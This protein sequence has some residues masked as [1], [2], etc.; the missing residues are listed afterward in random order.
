MD[1]LPSLIRRCGANIDKRIHN[2]HT[3]IPDEKLRN[4]LM[5]GMQACVPEADI[6]AEFPGANLFL[7]DYGMRCLHLPLFGE[8]LSK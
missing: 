6:Q 3:S 4:D 2:L 7:G 5:L 1:L 8:I